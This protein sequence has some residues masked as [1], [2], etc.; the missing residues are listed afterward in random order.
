MQ[1][2][3]F[4]IVYFLLSLLFQTQG[5]YA[6]DSGDL[7]TAAVTAPVAHPSGYPLYT[8]LGWILSHL[9]VFSPVW[10]VT[11]VSSLAHAATLY[12]VYQLTLAIS[13][14][15]FAAWFAVLLLAGNYLFLLYSLTPEVFGLLDLFIVSLF[16]LLYQL[17]LHKDFKYMVWFAALF[18]LSLSHHHMSVFLGPA[19]LYA[20]YMATRKR[21][22]LTWVHWAKAFGAWFG[23]LLPHLYIPLAARGESMINWNNAVDWD[24]FVR[25]ITRA[26][27][28]TFQSGAPAGA[29]I[30]QRLFNVEAYTQFF[31]LDFSFIGA[32]FFL[33]GV[34][35]VW[36]KNREAV[37]LWMLALITL[38][39]AFFFYAS[40]PISGRFA[41]GTYERFML[42]SYVLV[43][44]LI[45]CG[46][47]V[48]GSWIRVFLSRMRLTKSANI[49]SIV[50]AG[51]FLYP[52]LLGAVNIWR[53]T[54]LA[55][56]K[57]A[58]HL[59]HDI[60][61]SS[62]DRAIVLLV[63]DASLFTTQYVRYGL[64]ERSDTAVVH[65]ARLTLPEY[66]QLL[67]KHFPD[68]IIPPDSPSFIQ[69]FLI[70][71]SK[72]RPIVSNS[73]LPVPDGFAWLPHGMLLRLVDEKTAPTD[74]M[75]IDT[76]V[77]LW[78][79]FSHPKS[80][81][82][83]RYNHLMLAN[84][85]DEY[86]D[87]A[88]RFGDV[89]GSSGNLKLA[90]IQ[91]ERAISYDSD[92]NNTD[93]YTRLG[94]T[95]TL[96]GECDAALA[97]FDTVLSLESSPDPEL[98]KFQAITYRDCLK[99]ASGAAVLFDQYERAQKQRERSLEQL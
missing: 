37:V 79:R 71:N 9:G 26:D 18:G 93:A 33:L 83:G 60:L 82:L 58:E 43:A 52:L 59:A 25:L 17:M 10:R 27:Y 96:L 8:L 19:A 13:G 55:T 85:S 97:S 99:D 32:S 54:G 76:N 98:Y 90:K 30:V 81:I 64:G 29:G 86:A 50:V 38:G 47:V 39:P 73:I 70:Q 46:L 24:G 94:I 88:L 74:Q 65:L 20:L 68:I 22:M 80:G 12:V 23:G 48:L 53:F 72:V 6:G 44:P 57:T 51:V 45:A 91:F 66:Q 34:L 5:I 40:F 95:Q 28:G 62:P 15:R 56:D 14:K 77:T 2:L 31:L 36:R 67:V 11:I 84:I 16:Y 89:L 1:A 75:L 78:E 61:A 35:F 49:A 92:G 69:D 3:L 7:V 42:P 63:H 41:L 87:S 21:L 4:S